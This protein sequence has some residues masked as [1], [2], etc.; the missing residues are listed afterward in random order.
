MNKLSNKWDMVLIDFD[1]V[2]SKN[3]VSIMSRAINGFMNQYVPT[4]I[5]ATKEAIR[6][7][8]GLPMKTSVN[9]LLESFGILE[10]LPDL[11]QT[12]MSMEKIVGENIEIQSDFYPFIEFCKQ[13]EIPFRIFSMADKTQTHVRE[14]LEKIGE[15]SFFNIEG[16]TKQNIKLYPKIAKELKLD[17]NKCLM[18]D[19]SCVAL[20]TAK[21]FGIKTVMMENELVTKKDFQIWQP[22]ID[23]CANSFDQVLQILISNNA[24]ALGVN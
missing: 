7:S 1:G 15:D 16:Y 22:H 11:Y 13:N 18:I 23:H 17:L 9:I 8:V 20:S 14:V 2:I 24:Y 6:N 10:A 19:D 21:K 12:M 4:P 5:E 3:V